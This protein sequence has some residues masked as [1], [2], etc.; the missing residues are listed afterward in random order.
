MYLT[1]FSEHMSLSIYHTQFYLVIQAG[2]YR[3]TAAGHQSL[4]Q[5]KWSV[6][7]RVIRGGGNVPLP[8]L[9]LRLSYSFP[10]MPPPPLV[11]ACKDER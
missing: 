8:F 5:G 6:G 11:F 3:E 2:I 9:V 7:R 1:F 4:G 10:S